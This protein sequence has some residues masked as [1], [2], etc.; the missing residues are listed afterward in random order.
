VTIES[1]ANTADAAQGA[2]KNLQSEM[3]LAKLR[4]QGFSGVNMVSTMVKVR[5]YRI[6]D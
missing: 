5:V 2:I 4:D 6:L 3:F 1:A